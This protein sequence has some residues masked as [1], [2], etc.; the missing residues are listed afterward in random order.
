MERN[1]RA[2]LYPYA[3]SPAPWTL[4]A[5][6][7]LFT[8]LLPMTHQATQETEWLSDDF[9][10]LAELLSDDGWQTAAFTN[11][12]WVG[13]RT[14]LLQGFENVD[15]MWRYPEPQGAAQTPRAVRKWLDERDPM[16]PFFVFVN[17]I[18]PHWRY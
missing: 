5:H 8:G 1:E 7:S 6:A 3:Y 12:A 18:D 17:L 13:E 11:N 16:R 9:E 15:E 10:T 2:Q 4:P 14:N